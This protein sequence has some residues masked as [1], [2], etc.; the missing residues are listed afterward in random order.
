MIGA[1]ENAPKLLQTFDSRLAKITAASQ[2]LQGVAKNGLNSDIDA[3]CEQ[4]IIGAK[5]A[6]EDFNSKRSPITQKLYEVIKMFTAK[7]NAV[8]AEMD[9][10]QAIRN[11]FAKQVAEENERKRRESELSRIKAEEKIQITGDIELSIRTFMRCEIDK[12]KQGIVNSLKSVTDDNFDKKL[13]GLKGLP[14]EYD[15]KKWESF[16]TGI[17]SKHG[18]PDAAIESDLKGKLKD[19]LFKCY[20]TEIQEWKNS[21]LQDMKAMKSEMDDEKR[22]AMVDAAQKRIKEDTALAMDVESAKVDANSDAQ[23][24]DLALSAIDDEDSEMPENRTG[25]KIIVSRNS[26]YAALAAYWFSTQAKN[27]SG[28][29][30]KLSIGKMMREIEK[31]AHST[32]EMLDI[33]G[34]KYEVEYKAI[35]RKSRA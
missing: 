28:D 13:E 12:L 3:K 10:I 25:Y 11:N 16:S 34:I 1:A 5:K 26:A 20:R 23:K 6:K 19:E 35:N 15:V 31:H 32:G 24:A 18:H 33:E 17:K 2:T 9:T 30:E 14:I 7:E 8:Q 27:F 21:A 29:F 22:K 4:F